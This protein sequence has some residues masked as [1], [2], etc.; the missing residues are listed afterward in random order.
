[1]C[2]GP[3]GMDDLEVGC[4][5][6]CHE[7]PDCHSAYCR[8]VGGPDRCKARDFQPLDYEEELRLIGVE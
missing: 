6:Q 1:M 2:S 7:C 3:L 8:K 5:C 4:D